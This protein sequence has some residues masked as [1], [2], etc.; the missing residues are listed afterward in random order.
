MKNT[1]HICYITTIK[2]KSLKL[3]HIHGNNWKDIDSDGNPN[4][5]ELTFVN[6][7]A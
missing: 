5:V 1:N 4:D 3:I 7:R 2:N 6:I